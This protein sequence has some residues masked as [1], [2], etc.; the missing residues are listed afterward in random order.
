MHGISH[1]SHKNLLNSTLLSYNH[2]RNSKVVEIGSDFDKTLM[3]MQSKIKV[4]S[5]KTHG[6]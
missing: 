6:G 1:S 4:K 2:K 3:L 5:H